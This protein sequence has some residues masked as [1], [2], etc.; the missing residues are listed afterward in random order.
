MDE[1]RHILIVDDDERVLFVLRRALMRLND[2]YEI[3]TAQD[4]RDAADNVRSRKFDLVITDLRMPGLDGVELTRVINSAS[5]ETV[6]VWITAYGC[7]ELER[8]SA[9]LNVYGCL[10]KPLRSASSVK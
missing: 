1:C 9:Q 10:E 6:V 7:Q 2:G 4:G 3:E 5:A 8:E